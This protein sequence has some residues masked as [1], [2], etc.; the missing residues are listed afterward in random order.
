MRRILTRVHIVLVKCAHCTE[1]E[2]FKMRYT[3]IVIFTIDILFAHKRIKL[4]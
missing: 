1:L 4:N 2:F 3:A